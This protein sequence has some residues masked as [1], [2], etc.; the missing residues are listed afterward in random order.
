MH[1]GHTVHR[2]PQRD[3]IVTAH[4]EERRPLRVEGIKNLNVGYQTGVR[5]QY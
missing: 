2:F 1:I 5:R 3:V 4:G